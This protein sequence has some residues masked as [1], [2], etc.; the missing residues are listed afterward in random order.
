[1]APILNFKCPPDKRL[2]VI[3]NEVLFDA[4]NFISLIIHQSFATRETHYLL[5]VWASVEMACSNM[6]FQLQ[7]EQWVQFKS[8]QWIPGDK[9]F[10][11]RYRIAQ[12]T[13]IM[14]CF[15]MIKLIRF[16]LIGL[17]VYRFLF[18]K[19]FFSSQSYFEV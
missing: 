15:G 8:R 1:M 6:L 4:W 9:L 18:Q 3:T 11:F 17:I 12:C 13:W 2:D 5:F 7:D 14:F 10:C 19:Q 16:Y